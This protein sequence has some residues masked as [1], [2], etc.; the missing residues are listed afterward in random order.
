LKF[1]FTKVINPNYNIL[2]LTE[3]LR[4]I[5]FR[6]AT[7]PVSFLIDVSTKIVA[8]L[9]LIFQVRST[10]NLCRILSDDVNKGAAHRNIRRKGSEQIPS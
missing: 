9:W 7:P 5:I 8:T 6:C 2:G 3:K 1:Y 4:I 10:G